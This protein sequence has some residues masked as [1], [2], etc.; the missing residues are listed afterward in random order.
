MFP[1]LVLYKFVV[2]VDILVNLPLVMLPANASQVEVKA[3]QS[4][5]DTQTAEALM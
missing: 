2:L 1:P 4:V 3:A 5:C